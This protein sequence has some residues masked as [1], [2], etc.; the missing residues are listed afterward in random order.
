M[1]AYRPFLN[2]D[3]PQLAEVWRSQAGQRG[4]AQPMSVALWE[5]HVLSRPYFDRQGLIVAEE[6]GRLVG[7]VHAGFGPDDAERTLDLSLGSTMMLLVRPDRQ[8]QGIGRELL[9]RAEAYLSERG[10]GVLYAGAIRP[11][12]GFYQGLY[13]G[14][15]LPGV[16]RSSP[17]AHEFLTATGYRAI[18]QVVVLQRDLA[19]F[20][21]PVDRRAISLRRRVSTVVTADPVG[22][23]W[24]EACTRSSLDVTRYELLLAETGRVTAAL[25]T[26]ALHALS[27]TWGVPAAGIIE[28]A[29]EPEYRRQGH[30]LLLLSDVLKQLAQE[31][32]GLVEVQTMVHNTA[33]RNLYQ[34]FGF[35]QVD[36][37][38]VYRRE[39]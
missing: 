10:A 19:G 24:W 26:V 35:Q 2:T 1:I 5:Q 38:V 16:L 18:D 17:G 13:G 25:T 6:E 36:E 8:R 20:R 27:T 37:G 33:A 21:P 28:F 12:A 9:R 7:F 4:L 22:R 29:V 34:K 32:L 14:S 31:R 15:E 39:R 30:G 11:V 23:T 3:T